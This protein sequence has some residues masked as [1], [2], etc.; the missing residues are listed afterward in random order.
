VN[1]SCPSNRLMREWILMILLLAKV[2]AL[3][4]EADSF[5][6]WTMMHQLH[7]LEESLKIWQGLPLTVS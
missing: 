2:Y 7:Q 5:H 1:S 3:H 6:V 4:D